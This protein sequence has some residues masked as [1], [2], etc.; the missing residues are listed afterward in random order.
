M[1]TSF[2]LTVALLS[3]ADALGG[4]ASVNAAFDGLTQFRIQEAYET[5]DPAICL[6]TYTTEVTNRSGEISKRNNHAI[7]LIVSPDGLV[8]SH[9]HML[10]PN[11]KPF[12][13]K[14]V[15]GT[16]DDE[17][18]YDA[19][20]LD[21]PD[22]INVTFL[23]IRTDEE[24]EFPHVRFSEEDDIELGAP[25]FLIGVLGKSFD[26][27]HIVQTLR[28]GAVLEE[29]RTTYC[30]DQPISF[31][32]VGGPVMNAQGDAIGV[33]GFDLSSAEGG[34]LYTRNGHPLLYQAEL[35]R[36]YIENPPSEDGPD[37]DTE[38]AWLGVFTQPL[39]DDLA[40]Y[41][42]LDKTGG[43]VVSTVIQGSPAAKAGLRAGDVIID[44]N[45]TAVTAKQDQDVLGFTKLVRES[46]LGDIVP[47]RLIRDGNPTEIE[48]E[49][50]ARPKS[51]ED[52]LEFQD[53][54]FGLT[55]QEITQD[56][57]IMLN[58]TKDLKGVIVR[59]VRQGSSANLAR[60]R[61]GFIILAFGEHQ[62]AS[63]EDFEN[64]VAAI[65]KDQ[66]DEF[67]VFCRVRAN[68]AFFR[69]QPRWND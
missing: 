8:M 37:S 39:F 3:Q 32:Y 55:V 35:F 44:F 33:L 19:T 58:L 41:W 34:D 42:G 59:R 67:T 54:I 51:R 22:D 50:T 38:D 12:N 20:L 60:L 7:A 26:Y 45:G 18:E 48:I 63:V 30:L 69:I 36:Q 56:V 46:E 24:I 65:I 25:V 11:R 61:P 17:T 27:A 53:E 49:L 9:G 29:P 10:L 43:V 66:P 64:A 31:G 23:R 15:V 28:I 21:K 4:D 16:G 57:R 14:V 68:T 47:I 52:A 2:I 6:L 1:L 13:I 5:Y 62:I 40:E